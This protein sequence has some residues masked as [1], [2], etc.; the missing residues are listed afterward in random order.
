[1]T[2][3]W[4]YPKISFLHS[5]FNR[6]EEDVSEDKGSHATLNSITEDEQVS[7]PIHDDQKSEISV[8]S[9]HTEASPNVEKPTAVRKFSGKCL[10]TVNSCS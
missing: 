2:R 5:T 4:E 3:I 10:G 6:S 7:P 9:N 8:D 1:M